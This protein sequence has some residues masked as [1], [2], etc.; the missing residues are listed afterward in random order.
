MKVVLYASAENT[1]NAAEKK[2][3]ETAKKKK[4]KYFKGLRQVSVGE[5]LLTLKH[6]MVNNAEQFFGQHL[7]QLLTIDPDVLARQGKELT[8]EI[9]DEFKEFKER[10][11]TNTAL[12][13]MFDEYG[14]SYVTGIYLVNYKLSQT[15]K[16]DPPTLN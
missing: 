5:W 7:Q 10:L 2:E 8:D 3:E 4:T 6:P 16:S 14:D 12:R 15:K 1:S 11:R 9:K 13:N